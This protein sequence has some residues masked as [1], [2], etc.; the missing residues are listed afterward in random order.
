MKIYNYNH[1]S[2]RS[3]NDPKHVFIKHIISYAHN[4][5]IDPQRSG[6][7][8]KHAFI[9]PII[10]YAQNKTKVHSFFLHGRK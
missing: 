1:C 10:F 2:A 8:L 5:I 9:I 7:H 3:L 4:K 6:D